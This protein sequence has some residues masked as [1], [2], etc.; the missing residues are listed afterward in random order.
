MQNED[1]DNI[2]FEEIGHCF[3]KPF[4]VIIHIFKSEFRAGLRRFIQRLG[5]VTKDEFMVQKKLLDEA[6]RIIDQLKQTDG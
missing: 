6:Y 2:N 5:L 4:Q 3:P 1:I